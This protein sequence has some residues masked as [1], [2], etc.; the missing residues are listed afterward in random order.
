MKYYGLPRPHEGHV[1]CPFCCQQARQ[2]VQPQCL[3]ACRSFKYP[4]W[5]HC[6]RPAL[7]VRS[8]MPTAMTQAAPT[9]PILKTRPNTALLLSVSDLFFHRLNDQAK[10]LF[11]VTSLRWRVL[12][13]PSCAP[14]RA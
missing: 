10:L 2:A 13:H 14:E 11:Q 5:G 6:P 8:E 12:D 9:M 7:R 1:Y 3:Q 4:H